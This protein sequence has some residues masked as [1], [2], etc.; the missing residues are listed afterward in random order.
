[1]GRVFESIAELVGGT[2]LVRFSRFE[3]AAG[4]KGTILAKLEYFNPTSSTKDRIALAMIEEAERQG[5]I[6]PGDTFS[7]TTSGNTGISLA[8]LAAVKGYGF[9]TYIQDFVSKERKQVI[10]AYGAHLVNMGDVPQA[11]KAL[12]ESGGDF[13]AA[14]AAIKAMLSERGAT[15][16]DQMHN[17]QN[18]LSHFESTGQELWDDTD[19]KLDV[20]VAAV[21]TGGTVTGVGRYL[22]GKKAAV[23]VVA[24]QPKADEREITGIHRFSD[25]DERHFPANLD[26]SVVDE[27]VTVSASDAKRAA[28]AA[29]RYEGTLVGSSS[30]AALYAAVQ[31]ALREEAEGKVIAAILPDTGL[32]YLS[33]GLF[34]EDE[35]ELARGEVAV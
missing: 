2:P 8:A 22:K 35:G 23:K 26:L 32:R 33:T 7:E 31:V 28:Q 27:V 9:T 5:K 29:A 3:K 34:D 10:R 4:A 25:V 11:R 21:G 18:P 12:E 1:M 30:G 19:G 15:V 6:K 20:L 24:V 16:M 13:V 17:P 14:T